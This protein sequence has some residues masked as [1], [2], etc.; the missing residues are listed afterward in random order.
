MKLENIIS[1]FNKRGIEVKQEWNETWNANF[2]YIN[3][4]GQGFY[5]THNV[6]VMHGLTISHERPSKLINAICNLI[7]QEIKTGDYIVS[8][9]ESSTLR[10]QRWGYY[11]DFDVLIN[12]DYKY[13]KQEDM[14][15]NFDDIEKVDNKFWLIDDYCNKEDFNTL[16]E[17]YV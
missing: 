16:K 8:F 14:N 5:I 12:G 6:C 11:I 1:A 15:I 9:V 2:N 10:V 4:A 17:M 7:D 3:I 13:I